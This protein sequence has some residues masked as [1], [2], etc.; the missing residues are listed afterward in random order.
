MGP[1][2][3]AARSSE[4]YSSID[5]NG[6]Y[7]CNIAAQY[8][9]FFFQSFFFNEATTCQRLD[10][11]DASILYQGLDKGRTCSFMQLFPKNRERD[12][13]LHKT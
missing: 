10:D 8:L 4:S 12:K 13:I 5:S 2:K 1:Q 11:D 6:N 7:S 9:T 3:L